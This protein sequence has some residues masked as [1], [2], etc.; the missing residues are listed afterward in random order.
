[1][2]WECGWES[3]EFFWMLMRGKDLF[4]GVEK[5]VENEC[6]DLKLF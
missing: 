1:M 5:E 2:W 6:V 3:I 4:D